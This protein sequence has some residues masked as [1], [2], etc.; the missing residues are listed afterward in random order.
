MNC[1]VKNSKIIFNKSQKFVNAFEKY[2]LYTSTVCACF[3]CA[4]Y[5]IFNKKK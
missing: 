1:H 5:A 3:Y 4:E 2:N